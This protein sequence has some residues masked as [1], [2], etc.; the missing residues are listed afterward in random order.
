METTDKQKRVAVFSPW[1]PQ[2]STKIWVSEVTKPL[3]SC[4]KQSLDAGWHSSLGMEPI[5]L[6]RA[7]AYSNSTFSLNE[8]QFSW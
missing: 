3:G 1:E 4:G 8:S 2:T 5:L 6:P 7:L